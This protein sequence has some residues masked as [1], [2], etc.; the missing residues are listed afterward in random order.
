MSIAPTQYAVGLLGIYASSA[1]AAGSLWPASLDR[2]GA[3]VVSQRTDF[4]WYKC[5]LS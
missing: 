1:K 3:D 5:A 4:G 2:V